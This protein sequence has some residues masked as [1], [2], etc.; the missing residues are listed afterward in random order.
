MLFLFTEQFSE[1][2]TEKFNGKVTNRNNAA[3]SLLFI[4]SLIQPT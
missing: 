1:T 2:V 4:L 3:V